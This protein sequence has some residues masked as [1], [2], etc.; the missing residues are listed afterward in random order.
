M[1]S[2]GAVLPLL[3]AGLVTVIAG[4]SMSLQGRANGL[5]GPILGSAAYA[6]LVSFVIGLIV[7]VTMLA[8]S[9]RSRTATIVLVRLLRTKRLPWWMMLG[10]IS[11]VLVV[12]AQA[13]TVPLM[14]V[15]MFTM[16]FVSGQ[17]AGGIVVDAT[18]LPPGGRQHPTAVRVLGVMV[19]LAALVWGA[20]ERIDLGIPLWAPFLPFASGA[21]TTL[22][23]ATNGRIKAATRSAVVATAVNFTV[24]VALLVPLTAVLLI[25]GV[26]WVGFPTRPDQWWILTGGGLGV[27][28]IGLTALTVTR[29]GVLLL[30]LFALF[31]NL[32]GALLLDWLVPIPGSLVSLT[33]VLSAAGVLAGI[34]ITLLPSRR[35]RSGVRRSGV[36]P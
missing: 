33:T 31:G 23:Q 30:S 5:L 25:S 26:S 20:R 17:V 8:F 28:F 24:G 36:R 3:L 22:Q 21:L 2:T 9:S 11:G 14:G 18:A 10:G 7:V 6:A 1:R 35:R 29:L 34:G 19:V 27:V 16:A 15:A 12:V 32:L 13:T 4:A